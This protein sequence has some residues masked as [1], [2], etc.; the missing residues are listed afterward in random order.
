[1]PGIILQIV[2]I[3]AIIIALKRAGVMNGCEDGVVSEPAGQKG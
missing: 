2:M 3:P 1:M